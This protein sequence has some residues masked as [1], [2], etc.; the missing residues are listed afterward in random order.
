MNAEV[1]SALEN[2][3]DVIEEAVQGTTVG[4]DQ[5]KEGLVQ[6][7]ESVTETSGEVHLEI[8]TVKGIAKEKGSGIEKEKEMAVG[9]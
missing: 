3:T 8:D 1:T 2:A 5:E 6:E 9:K 4:A 7:T